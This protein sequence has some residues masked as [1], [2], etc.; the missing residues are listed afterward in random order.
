MSLHASTLRKLA[1]LNLSAEQ[2]AG[3]I[4]VLADIEDADEARKANQRE[5]VRHLVDKKFCLFPSGETN[6]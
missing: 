4:G 1:A 3:V 6:T 2:M 5:R